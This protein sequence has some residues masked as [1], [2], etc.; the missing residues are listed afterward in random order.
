MILPYSTAVIL[1][2]GKSS[3]MQR[4]KALL[5]FG[6]ANSLAQ[7]QHGR[8]SKIFS[9]VYISSKNNKFDFDVNVIADRYADSSPL[10]ALISIFETLEELEEV[11][12]L[13]VDAPFV[14]KGVIDTL[15]KNNDSV[16]VIV[17]ESNNGL[18]PLCAIYHRSCLIEAKKA[19]KAKRH[20]LQSLFKKLNVKRVKMT[21]EADFMNL[22]YPSEYKMA[23]KKWQP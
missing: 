2:G 8:L 23:Q 12:L 19:L 3:R 7:F 11:F 15:Y 17:A 20:R 18:E 6:E 14:S 22:N 13:S 9:K 1:A 4:D 5:P 16:D 21:N 10:V